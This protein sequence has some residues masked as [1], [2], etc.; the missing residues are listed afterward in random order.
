MSPK[1]QLE[2]AVAIA[3]NPSKL[4]AAA[5]A[6]GPKSVERQHIS[7]WLNR[8][9]GSCSGDYVLQVAKAVEY[10]VTPHQLRPD[11]YPNPTDGMPQKDAA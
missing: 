10:A 1:D 7:N 3:G 6:A 4:A 5:T 9:D 8:G 11:L 2:R